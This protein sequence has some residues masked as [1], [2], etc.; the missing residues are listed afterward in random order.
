M[1][2]GDVYVKLISYSAS[3]HLHTLRI[4]NSMGK[5]RYLYIYGKCAY[6]KTDPWRNLHIYLMLVLLRIINLERWKKYVSGRTQTDNETSN[7]Y[8][9]IY[10]LCSQFEMP[11]FL[12]VFVATRILLRSLNSRF[13]YEKAL[14]YVVWLAVKC[15]CVSKSVR[16]GSFSKSSCHSP[17]ATY[18]INADKR[19]AYGSDK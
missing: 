7:V 14:G 16:F 17:Q 15:L 6:L 13:L 5:A 3:L 2:C 9:F 11:Y 12:H 4:A 18:T 10:M 1:L 8:V 19:D